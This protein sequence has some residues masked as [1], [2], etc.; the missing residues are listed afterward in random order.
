MKHSM[1]CF[2]CLVPFH[3]ARIP[4]YP[5]VHVWLKLVKVSC[6][7]IFFCSLSNT[8]PAS[9]VLF[10]SEI[11]SLRAK[12][13]GSFLFW[14]LKIIFLPVLLNFQICSLSNFLLHIPCVCLFC[15]VSQFHRGLKIKQRN[16]FGSNH[17]YLNSY[18]LS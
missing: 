1:I 14:C 7:Q 16:H 15:F 9:L 12:Y 5:G 10:F 13:T 6:F 11:Q 2:C 18:F 3:L 8:T 17:I 4:V